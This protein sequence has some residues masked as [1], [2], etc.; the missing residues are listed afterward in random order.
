MCLYTKIIRKSAVVVSRHKFGSHAL[1]LELQYNDFCKSFHNIDMEIST[2]FILVNAQILSIRASYTW[3][4]AF[5]MVYRSLPKRKLV[6]LL[7]TGT[8]KQLTLI[9]TLFLS[10]FNINSSCLCF[11]RL[12]LTNTIYIYSLHYNFT[13]L[14]FKIFL[15]QITK[16]TVGTQVNNLPK[17]LWQSAIHSIELGRENSGAHANLF[18]SKFYKTFGASIYCTFVVDLY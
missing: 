9:V 15:F 6:L 11:L 1:R 8:K 17:G 5:L 4:H 7:A 2:L 13:T 18:L 12:I 14:L 3:V 16:G 10:I